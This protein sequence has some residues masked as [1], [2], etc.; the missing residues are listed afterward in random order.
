M[1]EC[2]YIYKHMCMFVCSYPCIC[3]CI[4][5]ANLSEEKEC[6]FLQIPYKLRVFISDG[7]TLNGSKHQ[8]IIHNII[9]FYVI[10]LSRVSHPLFSS[11]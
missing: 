1:C 6:F 3:F 10:V 7:F 2:V 9:Q 8:M 5:G 11:D 4:M